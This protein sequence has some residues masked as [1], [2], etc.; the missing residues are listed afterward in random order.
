MFN[1]FSLENKT[2]VITGASSGIGRQCAIDCSK[3]GAT[4]YMVARNEER[5]K[6]VM[7]ELTGVNHRYFLFDMN[8]QDQIIDLVDS[9]HEIGKKIDGLVCAAGIELT[10]PVKNL[11]YKDYQKVFDVNTFGHFELA[12]LLTTKR[13]FNAPGG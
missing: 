13:H 10:K 8:N 12:R 4:V 6:N 5:L 1:P 9:I 7:Q 11:E 3:M 2:I